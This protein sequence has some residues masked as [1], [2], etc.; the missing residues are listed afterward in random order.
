MTGEGGSP[1]IRRLPRRHALGGFMH[2]TSEPEKEDVSQAILFPATGATCEDQ[3]AAG[4]LTQE[5][6]DGLF[7]YIFRPSQHMRNHQLCVCCRGLQR[8]PLPMPT[9]IELQSTS[10]SRNWAGT[11]GLCIL[12]VSSSTIAMGPSPAVLLYQGA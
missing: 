2:R 5:A 1:E 3:Q 11:A 9:A 8:N 7:T 4:G 10:P 12:P 6:E